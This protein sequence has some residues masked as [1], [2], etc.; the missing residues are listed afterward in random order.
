MKMRWRRTAYT[1]TRRE[2]TPRRQ[3]AAERWIAKEAEKMAL[4]PEL[5]RE[6]TVEQRRKGAEDREDT[7]TTTMRAHHAKMWREARAARLFTTEGLNVPLMN[8]LLRDAV[9]AEVTDRPGL[10]EAIEQAEAAY[11]ELR[12]IDLAALAGKRPIEDAQEAELRA[13]AADRAYMCL[14]TDI[15]EGAVERAILLYSAQ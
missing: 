9:R 11:E 1:R 6:T 4:F 12:Q 2:W 3:A 14:L 13:R 15:A 5:R 8:G 7:M 10:N